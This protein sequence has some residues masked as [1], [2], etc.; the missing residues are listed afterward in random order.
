MSK[1]RASISNGR[2]EAVVQAVVEVPTTGRGS[3]QARG[4][5][6]EVASVRGHARG[7][8][9]TRGRAKEA[10]PDPLVNLNKDKVPPKFGAPLF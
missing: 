4:H 6:R 3:T 5:A 9:P 10:S 7:A 1:T 2:D 8:A